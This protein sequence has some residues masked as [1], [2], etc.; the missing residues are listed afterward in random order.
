MCQQRGLCLLPGNTICLFLMYVTS[1]VLPTLHLYQLSWCSTVMKIARK[2][3]IWELE[4]LL[5]R[6]NKSP[7]PNTEMPPQKIYYMSV[8]FSLALWLKY[9][10]V[11]GEVW[12]LVGLCMSFAKNVH[13]VFRSETPMSWPAHVSSWIYSWVIIQYDNLSSFSGIIS[14]WNHISRYRDTHLPCLNW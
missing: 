13:S 6:D 14:W 2:Q 9:C 4:S 1:L 3:G 8:F 5:S 11:I 10:S 7:T 12:G